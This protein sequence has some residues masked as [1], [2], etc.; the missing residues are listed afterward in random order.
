MNKK[1]ISILLIIFCTLLCVIPNIS[2]AASSTEIVIKGLDR[3][4]RYVFEKT[5]EK[6]FII[7]LRE[8][9]KI[10]SVKLEKIEN[11]KNIV[12]LNKDSKNN[13]KVKGI[14]L[15]EDMKKIQISK[16]L[17]KDEYTTFRITTCDS[18][19]ISKNKLV[20]YFRVKTRKSKNSQKSWYKINN[21]PRLSYSKSKGL[22]I[23]AKDYN[24]IESLK[25]VD[26]N[27]NNAVVNIGNELAGSS[28]IDKTYKIDLAKLK[29]KNNN[30]FLG[31]TVKDKSG[32][33]RTEEVIVKTEKKQVVTNTTSKKQVN[34]TTNS[35]NKSV[36][37]NENT[38]YISR[39]F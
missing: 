37:S 33:T 31:I 1:M 5:N 6:T 30:Y 3:A 16:S 8:K 13:K 29:S 34:T 26:R 9:S 36:R 28:E 20:S 11:G 10:S 22:K 2:Y 15:S 24:K 23:E 7:E 4:P 39:K 38:I 14:T 35:N 12:L 18:N 32:I 27:N 17:L 21:S 19:S 25:I